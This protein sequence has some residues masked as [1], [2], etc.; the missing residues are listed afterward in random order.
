MRTNRFGC[1]T[2]TVVK[3]DKSISAQIENGQKWLIPLRDLRNWIQEER[4]KPKNRSHKRRNGTNAVI[5]YGGVELKHFYK[6]L[7]KNEQ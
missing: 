2:C 3:K 7:I 1:W 5:P 6:L 4:N